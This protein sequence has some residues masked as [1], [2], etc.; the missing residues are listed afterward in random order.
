MKKQ[1]EEIIPEEN[2]IKEANT[3]MALGAGVGVLGTASAL[4]AGAVCPLC[5]FIA[6][7]L[8]GVGAYKRWKLSRKQTNK[9]TDNQN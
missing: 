2:E 8:V 4:L 1:F 7:G 9:K 3:C 5:I 6:P